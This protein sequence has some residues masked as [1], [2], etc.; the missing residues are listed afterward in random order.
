MIAKTYRALRGSRENNVWSP[1]G[2]W[3]VTVTLY[4]SNAGLRGFTNIPLARL[5]ANA[6]WQGHRHFR[7]MGLWYKLRG[8]AFFN[9]RWMVIKS[10]LLSWL[11]PIAMPLHFS[12]EVREFEPPFRAGRGVSIW[13]WGRTHLVIGRWEP[14]GY[15]LDAELEQVLAAGSEVCDDLGLG[16]YQPD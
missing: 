12:A 8:W 7:L 3:F 5:Q 9:L 15:D 2:N 13:L 14:S 4:R 11:R 6:R 10:W 16:V 1:F